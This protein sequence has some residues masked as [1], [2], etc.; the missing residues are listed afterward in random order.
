MV[1]RRQGGAAWHVSSG[2]HRMPT[3]ARFI[4]RYGY[5]WPYYFTPYYGFNYW[6]YWGYGPN[7]WYRPFWTYAYP[8]PWPYFWPYFRAR[9]YGLIQ[10]LPIVFTNM[11]VIVGGYCGPRA[12]IGI[13]IGCRWCW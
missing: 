9:Y 13:R 4:P 3:R 10:P 6:P 11:P 1:G 2:V 12:S 5:S 7:L 8:R